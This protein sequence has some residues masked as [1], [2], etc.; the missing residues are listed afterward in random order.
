MRILLVIIAF[1]ISLHPATAEDDSRA[2]VGEILEELPGNSA[3]GT[4]EAAWPYPTIITHSAHWH[5]MN[6]AIR[7]QRIHFI[8]YHDG[9]EDLYDRV[10]DLYQWKNLANDPAYTATKTEL[11]KWLPKINAEHH[12]ASRP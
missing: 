6:H 10:A 9:G 3:N 7:S 1:F 8:R 12:R 5:G 2:R 4:P 11:K